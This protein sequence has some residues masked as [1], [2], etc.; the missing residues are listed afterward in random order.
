MLV[1]GHE[2]ESTLTRAQLWDELIDLDNIAQWSALDECVSTDSACLE[3]TSSYLCKHDNGFDGLEASV[4]VTDYTPLECLALHTSTP[5]ADLDERLDLTDHL[6]GS[7]VSY[8]VDATSANFGPAATVWLHRHVHHV[9]DKLE[10][11]ANREL[12]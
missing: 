1:E 11:F 12:A 7:L 2:I 9:C 4:E 3:P 8:S 5:M 10:E 6:G